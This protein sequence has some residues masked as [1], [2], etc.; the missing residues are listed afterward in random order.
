MKD[1]NTQ[2]IFIVDDDPF[3]IELLREIL[4]ELGYN[5]VDGFESGEDCMQNINL[6]P[7]VIFLD[8][9]ME[10]SDGISTLK[11]IKEFYADICVIFTT[12]KEDINVAVS[13]MRHGSFDYLLKTNV[14]KKEVQNILKKVAK[15]NVQTGKI[16]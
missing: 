4:N 6:Q 12:A 8:Y 1:Q 5:N 15:T 16:Y 13:A 7:E 10:K 14:T 9:Q 2:K 11:N 3:W